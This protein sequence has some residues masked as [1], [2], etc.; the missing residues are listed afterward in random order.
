[1][2]VTAGNALLWSSNLVSRVIPHPGATGI[3]PSF[4]DTGRYVLMPFTI[5]KDAFYK[6]Y[7]VKNSRELETVQ[8]RETARDLRIVAGTWVVARGG[9][10]TVLD[11]YAIE[12]GKKVASIQIDGDQIAEN[13]GA[14]IGVS[15]AG[16]KSTIES[17]NL[18]TRRKTKVTIPDS[19]FASISV[20]RDGRF[21][22]TQQNGVVR[23]W[24]L[25]ASPPKVDGLTTEELLGLACKQLSRFGYDSDVR[26]VCATHK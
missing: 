1:M 9:D 6:L 19:G 13:G 2:T 4:D 15:R 7:D 18:P 12:T 10:G 22:M 25:H 20:S 26:E 11:Y 14:M 16:E 17:L 23:V 21:V 24:D 3:K 5:E 8:L